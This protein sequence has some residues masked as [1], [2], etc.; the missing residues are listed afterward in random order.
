MKYLV[1]FGAIALLL[2]VIFCTWKSEYGTVKA[3]DQRAKLSL[4]ALLTLLAVVV[5][6]KTYLYVALLSSPN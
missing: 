2:S 3:W 5:L 1:T 6:H 4:G